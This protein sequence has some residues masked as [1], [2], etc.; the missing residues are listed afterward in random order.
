MTSI[1]SSRKEA[2]AVVLEDALA[3]LGP[4]GG[5]WMQGLYAIHEDSKQERY[6]AVG[7]IRKVAYGKVWPEYGEKDNE[8]VNVYHEARHSLASAAGVHSV[9]AWNDRSQ[10][11]FPEVRD[12]FRKA[13]AALRGK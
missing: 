3:L 8:A 5:H 7:A 1:A 11:T 2:A 6:C 9:T 4:K 13:I 12:A 10:R